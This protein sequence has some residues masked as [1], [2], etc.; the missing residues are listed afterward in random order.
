MTIINWIP[1]QLDGVCVA[2]GQHVSK[3]TWILTSPT[4]VRKLTLS[5]R[6]VG[7]TTLRSNSTSVPCFFMLNFSYP[8]VVKYL[9]IC[10]LQIQVVLHNK[11]TVQNLFWW[12]VVGWSVKVASDCKEL[13]KVAMC[14]WVC[15]LF[16]VKLAGQE[17]RRYAD[18]FSLIQIRSSGNKS[19]GSHISIKV[20]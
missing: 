18:L 20:V 1:A 12:D 15:Y 9:Q 8:A 17:C 7:M 13:L 2:Q 16:S 11:Q 4:L 14:G 19:S 3:K 10:R 5:L 6:S